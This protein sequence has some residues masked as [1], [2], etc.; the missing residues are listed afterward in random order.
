MGMIEY[1]PLD[2]LG[3]RLM[4]GQMP[5]E[6][7]VVVQIHCPQLDEGRLF[8]RRPS[9]IGEETYR[10]FPKCFRS[11]YYLISLRPLCPMSLIGVVIGVGRPQMPAFQGRTV[12]NH[13]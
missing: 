2:L 7:P 13:F 1:C 12:E 6:H 4:A 3:A 10:L 11:L 5:L 8:Y 9:L